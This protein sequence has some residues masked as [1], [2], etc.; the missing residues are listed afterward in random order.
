MQELRSPVLMFDGVSKRFTDGTVALAGVDLSVASGEFVSVVGPS[1]CGKSTLLRIAS[2]LTAASE[3]AVVV[4]TSK[5]GFVFQTRR[6]CPGAPSRPTSSCSPS[7]A[8]CRGRSAAAALTRRS[9]W[10]G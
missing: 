6:C 5:I 8:G 1:D 9:S 3:G 7:S 4:D 10:W 2:G